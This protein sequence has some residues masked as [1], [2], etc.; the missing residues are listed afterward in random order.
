VV[1][2]GGRAGH[3]AEIGLALAAVCLAVSGLLR[4][5]PGSGL[6]DYGSFVASG[7]AAAEGLDPYGIY[8][9]TF[10][11]VLPGFESWNPN[12]NPPVSLPLFQL[13]DL[14]D[15]AVGFRVW[16]A[17]SLLCY[18]MAVLL[19]VRRHGG[20]R[21]ALAAAWAFALAGFW[22]TLVLGQIYLPLVLAAAGAWLLLDAGRPGAAGLLIGLV[23]AVKPNFLAWP[24]LLL[25]AGHRRPAVVALAAAALLSLAPAALYGPGVYARWVDLVLSDRDRAVF[26][27][28]VSLWGLAARAGLAPAGPILGAALLAALAAWA[29]RARPGA[30]EASALGLLGALLAAPVAWVHYTLFLLPVLLVHRR[31]P[32]ARAA[33]VGLVVPVPLVL[34]LLD[35][36]AWVRV[37]VGS[38]YNWAVLSCLVAAAWRTRS[39]VRPAG[40]AGR[41]APAEAGG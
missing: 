36:P 27:T 2:V 17:V 26:L 32:L 35:D 23:V 9:L 30:L 18:A 4:A 20:R 22:D 25:L 15:P 19:L 33:A 13:L 39:R 10:H 31:S 11:V 21:R 8:P 5:L 1:R 28:N 12:L 16:W 29:W 7:R 34:R 37:G 41:G 24:A 3:A 38:V 14:L 40:G 6:L